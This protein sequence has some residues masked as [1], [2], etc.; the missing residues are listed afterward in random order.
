MLANKSFSGPLNISRLGSSDYTVPLKLNVLPGHLSG[1]AI[2]AF[3]TARERGNQGLQ[4][5]WTCET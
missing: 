1:T 4:Y 3:G 5:G 2:D